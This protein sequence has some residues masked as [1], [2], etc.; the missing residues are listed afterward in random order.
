MG[1]NFKNAAEGIRSTYRIVLGATVSFLP[2]VLFF[3]VKDSTIDLLPVIIF[4]LLT[5]WV[6]ISEL[7][8]IEDITNYYTNPSKL[9]V[10][11]SMIYL[12]VLTMLPLAIILG[13]DKSNV[14]KE[15]MVILVGEGRYRSIQRELS[16]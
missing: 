8:S 14:L 1:S 15:Y 10:F 13:L 12:I 6:I 5:W 4:W 3:L 7:W 11:V 16:G 9:S 2:F